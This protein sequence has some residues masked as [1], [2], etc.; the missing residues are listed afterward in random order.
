MNSQPKSFENETRRV[1]NSK[2]SAGDAGEGRSGPNS[3]MEDKS[4]KIEGQLPRWQSQV[5][6]VTEPRRGDYDFGRRVSKTKL[7]E[8]RIRN[9]QLVMPVKADSAKTAAQQKIPPK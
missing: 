8:F 7:R 3:I 9:S 6:Q 4:L 5:G 2:L 1:S